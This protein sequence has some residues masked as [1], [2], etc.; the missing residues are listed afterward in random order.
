MT[1]AAATSIPANKPR[2][3][4]FKHKTPK[5]RLKSLLDKESRLISTIE[6]SKVKLTEVQKE[7]PKLQSEIAG[8]EFL[9]IL[10]N[11]FIAISESLES[12]SFSTADIIQMVRDGEFEKLQK[13]SNAL[14]SNAAVSGGLKN[15]GFENSSKNPALQ[16]SDISILDDLEK[17]SFENSSKNLTPEDSG[18]A[19]SADLE[20][21]VFPKIR[22]LGQSPNLTE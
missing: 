13:I 17:K 4:T 21:K 8:M 20:N 16:N 12:M 6:A 5:E 9:S 22:V 7:I 11:D 15:E 10:P 18:I 19:I 3:K 2:N 1:S 14:N